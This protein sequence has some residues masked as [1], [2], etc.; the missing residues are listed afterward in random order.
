M[1]KMHS[2]RFTAGQRINDSFVLVRNFK[3][4]TTIKHKNEW[5]WECKCDCGKTFTCRENKVLN[6]YGC[7]SCTNKITQRNIALEKKNGVEHYGLKN[8]LL[9]DY[10]QGAVKRGKEFKLTFDQFVNLMEQDCFYC[11]AKPIIHTYELQYMQFKL[12]LGLIM[13]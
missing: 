11:G 2:S 6:R 10:R 13:E 9:K 3:R 1:G 7:H 12:K 4:K 8:R 5:L